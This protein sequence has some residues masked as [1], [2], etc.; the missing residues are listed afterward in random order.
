VYIYNNNVYPVINHWLTLQSGFSRRRVSFPKRLAQEFRPLFAELEATWIKV[1]ELPNTQPN[2]HFFARSF[3]LHL[4][5]LM[6]S[7]FIFNRVRKEALAVAMQ[8]HP[9]RLAVSVSKLPTRVQL[10]RWR[11]V[12]PVSWQSSMLKIPSQWL[13]K[14]GD[15][16]NPIYNL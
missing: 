9:T 10:K 11:D 7:C 1:K 6:I 13:P 15:M 2:H 5:E 4:D 12:S 3:S 8:P 16:E 14:M